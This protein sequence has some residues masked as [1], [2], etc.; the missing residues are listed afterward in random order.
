MRK[1]LPLFTLFMVG[2]IALGLLVG[3]RQASNS[4]N[5]ADQTVFVHGQSLA[6]TSVADNFLNEEPDKLLW[7]SGFTWAGRFYLDRLDL[8]SDSSRDG[9]DKRI[10][11]AKPQR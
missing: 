2:V 10:P 9:G 8:R 1:R 4:L 11:P 6:D 3:L 5:M 7:D